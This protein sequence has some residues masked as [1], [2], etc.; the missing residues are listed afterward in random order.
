MAYPLA[1]RESM[2]CQVFLFLY[3]EVDTIDQATLV[4]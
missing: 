2:P 3:E 4:R 1:R